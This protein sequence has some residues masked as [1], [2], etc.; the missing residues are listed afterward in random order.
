VLKLGILKI[1]S[2]TLSLSNGRK[3]EVERSIQSSYFLAIE[4]TY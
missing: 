1:E 4:R 2:V 3:F